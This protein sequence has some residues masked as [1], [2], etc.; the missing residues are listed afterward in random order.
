[1]HFSFPFEAV[2]ETD[3]LQLYGCNGTA[4]YTQFVEKLGHENFEAKGVMLL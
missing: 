4:C 1:M 3:R 2:N